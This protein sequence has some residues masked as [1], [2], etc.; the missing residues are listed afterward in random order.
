MTQNIHMYIL[1]Y[2][3]SIFL[4]EKKLEYCLIIKKYTID[5][6]IDFL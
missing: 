4:L 3:I 6:A 5:K 1:L 2:E